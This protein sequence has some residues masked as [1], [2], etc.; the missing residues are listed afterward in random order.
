VNVEALVH[1]GLS[2]QKQTNMFSKF[3][4]HWDIKYYF[5]GFS[6]E[7]G[8]KNTP[9]DGNYLRLTESLETAKISRRTQVSLL[10]FSCFFSC[11]YRG[12]SLSSVPFNSVTGDMS[13]LR[14]THSA[15]M[16]LDHCLDVTMTSPGNVPS[17]QGRA[18]RSGVRARPSYFGRCSGVTSSYILTF[19]KAASI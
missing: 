12:G 1:R 5:R 6:M 13:L 15:G 19:L 7:E 17:P 2:R 16:L 9:V 8:F 11:P 10:E 14:R 3:G 18:G 4:V